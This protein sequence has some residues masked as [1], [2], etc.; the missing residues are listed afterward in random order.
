MAGVANVDESHRFSLPFVGVAVR[1][2]VVQLQRSSGHVGDVFAGGRRVLVVVLFGLDCS[3]VIHH[4][5]A[6]AE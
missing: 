1:S 3:F 2:A 6:S 4:I 5:G